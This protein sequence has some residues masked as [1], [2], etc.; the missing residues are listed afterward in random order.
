MIIPDICITF[1]AGILG[2]AYPILLGV[3]SRLDEKYSSILVVSL[4]FMEREWKFFRASLISSL[5]G[6]LLYILVNVRLLVGDTP[7]YVIYVISALLVLSTILLIISFFRFAN[8][9]IIYYTPSKIVPYFTRKKETKDHIFFQALADI[10]YVSVRKQDYEIVH[11]IAKYIYQTF[12]NFREVSKETVIEYPYIYYEMTSKLIQE[13][14]NHNNRRYNYLIRFSLGGIWFFGEGQE[15]TI[16]ESTFS[17]QWDNL[18]LAIDGGRGDMVRTY[19]EVAHQHF[20]NYLR[21]VSITYNNNEGHISKENADEVKIRQDE[22]ERFL[23]F[24]YALGGHL[25]YKGQYESIRNMFRHTSS[26]PPSYDLL[27]LSMT[28]VFQVFFKFLDPYQRNFLFIGKRYRFTDSFG[29]QDESLVNYNVCKYA[30]ILF[31]RQYTIVEYYIYVKPLK[32]PSIPKLQSEKTLWIEYMDYFKRYVS[33]VLNDEE[34]LRGLKYSYMKDDWFKKH[35][36]PLPLE[37]IDN[38]KSEVEKDYHQTEQNQEIPEKM[39]AMFH[40]S[41]NKIVSETLDTYKNIFNNKS[42]GRIKYYAIGRQEIIEKAAFSDDTSVDYG[43]YRSSITWYVS[44][45]IKNTVSETF[46]YRQSKNYLLRENDLFKAIDRLEHNRNEYVIVN[47]GI[48]I[49][50]FMDFVKVKGLTSNSYNGLEII[51][52]EVYEKQIMNPTLFLL[53]KQN[54]PYLEN[55]DLSSDETKKYQLTIRNKE[56]FLYSSLI[57]LNKQ[58]EIREQ[59]SMQYDG[60]IHDLSKFALQVVGLTLEIRWKKNIKVIGLSPYSEFRNNGLPNSLNDVSFPRN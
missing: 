8:K 37:F 21:P 28:E 2:I 27:P 26:S 10:L 12:K 51:T 45:N 52:F 36:K 13:L 58:Q 41:V 54:L 14:V 44:Q 22:R 50:Y 47:F 49:Q 46:Y 29:L 31:L 20:I 48:D 5:I 39:E 32:T 23:E 1:I 53:K 55:K 7:R 17:W 34:L 42:S 38:V 6:I 33:E 35:E 18:R 3:I 57:D 40:D 59:I 9:I 24:N 19:W 16:H 4:F 11:T 43:N 56:H 15:R 30:A 60:Q 25:L